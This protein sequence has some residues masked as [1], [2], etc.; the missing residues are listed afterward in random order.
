MYCLYLR[1]PLNQEMCFVAWEWAFANTFLD[2]FAI[3]SSRCRGGCG[4]GWPVG[5]KLHPPFTTTT[6]PAC[7]GFMP[8]GGV[9]RWD[10][11]VRWSMK[12]WQAVPFHMERFEPLPLVTLFWE[13]RGGWLRTKGGAWK[14]EMEW[15][16]KAKSSIAGWS[17]LAAAKEWAMSGVSSLDAFVT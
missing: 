1:V 15:G 9:S 2:I 16:P 14:L 4:K 8:R 11:G 10:R 17:A 5:R 6:T 3:C 13:E 12:E 7:C